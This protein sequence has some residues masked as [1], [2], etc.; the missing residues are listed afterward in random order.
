LPISQDLLR[1]DNLAPE[2][3]DLS[4]VLY[5]KDVDSKSYIVPI[6]DGIPT[7][8][9]NTDSIDVPLFMIASNPALLKKEL[10]QALE[11]Y[12]TP[13]EI[14]KHYIA[15]A[16][17][18]ID[19]QIDIEVLKA[20]NTAV[21][22]SHTISVS[23]NISLSELN[24]AIAMLLE[25][26]QSISSI[27]MS[28]MRFKDLMFHDSLQDFKQT[29]NFHQNANIR[30]YYKN[31]PVYVNTQVPKNCVYILSNPDCIGAIP[32]SEIIIKDTEFVVGEREE[33]KL[34][35]IHKRYCTQEGYDLMIN[36]YAYNWTV[37]VK[38]GVA[39]LNSWP[40]VRIITNNGNQ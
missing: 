22:K 24:L 34:N 28:P 32:K 13:E 8:S 6:R 23:G 12:G 33:P 10:D 18:S 29:N 35:N 30:A 5:R 4:S 3:L 2:E 37:C 40:I 27:V 7:C 39:V 11:I 14:K 1:V 16:I 9:E 21:D 36:K 17:E 15:R 25:H 19:R 31:I 26:T 20:I 38:I